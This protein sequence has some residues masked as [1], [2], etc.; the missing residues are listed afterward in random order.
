MPVTATFKSSFPKINNRINAQVPYHRNQT[1]SGCVDF[2][3]VISAKAVAGQISAGKLFNITDGGSVTGII[4]RNDYLT[5]HLGNLPHITVKNLPVDIF[6]DK[7]G[8][9]VVKLKR[10]AIGSINY[11]SLPVGAYRKL[12][13]EEIQNIAAPAKLPEPKSK[14]KAGESQ[15]NQTKSFRNSR[16]L[17]VK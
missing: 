12:D 4:R 3:A 11:D 1:T 10:T 17:K 13:A 16:R 6:E 5:S 15:K 9:S 7:F 14:N 2:S 8:H